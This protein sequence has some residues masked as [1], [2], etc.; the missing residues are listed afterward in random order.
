VHVV[1]VYR[2][3]PGMESELLAETQRHVPLLRE[4][5]LATDAPSLVL[6]ASDGAL[7]ECFEWVSREAIAT[8]HEHPDVAA[9]WSRYETCCTYSTL[10]DLPNSSAMFAEFDYV[11]TF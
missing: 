1:A 5:G 10:G 11:G 6:R 9:M 2:P 3:T 4:L 7:V 8:A